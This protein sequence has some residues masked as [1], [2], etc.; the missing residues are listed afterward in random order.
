MKY[1]A[2]VTTLRLF[3][4]LCTGCGMCSVVCPHGVLAIE[5]GLARIMDRDACM[6]CGACA[7]N[8]P[9]EA[10]RVNAGVGCAQAV[11]NSALGRSGD[12]C[13]GLEDY[14][15]P[16]VDSQSSKKDCSCEEE[17]SRQSRPGCC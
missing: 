1:L 14:T 2:N 9:Q 11:I 15:F 13:C 17:P 5:R 10:I 8:C 4:D 16:G 3:E 7:N 12:A 6:E